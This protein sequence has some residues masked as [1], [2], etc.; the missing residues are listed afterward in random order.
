MATRFSTWWPAKVM[1]ETLRS[2]RCAIY[3]RKSTEEGLDQDFNS[4]QA[5]R[6]AGEA[7]IRSQRQ[8]GWVA[9]PETYDDG[10]YT[11]ANLERPA[12]QRL[13]HEMGE[14]K[15]DCVIVYK[16]D[17]LSRSLLDFAR[18]M[19]VFEQQG[20]SFVSVTQE[21]N[22]T[23]S[24]GRLTL[25]ILLSF[26]QFERE[27][28]GERTRDKLGA[29]R[30]KGKWIGGIPILGYD[31]ASAGGRLVVNAAEAEQVR[32]IFAIAASAEN[33]EKA[34]QE[35]ARRGIETK[36]WTS[37]TGRHHA[38][39]AI[40]KSTLRA[41]LGNVLYIGSIRHK[42]TVY[43]GE[44]TG[45]VDPAIWEQVNRQLEARGRFQTGKK[46]RR[47]Q[48]V[49]NGCVYCDQCG[50]AMVVQATTR[51]GRRYQYF[52]CPRGKSGE[53]GQAPVAIG[54][55]ETAVIRQVCGGESTANPTR[56]RQRLQRVAYHSG[57]RRVRVEM[58]DGNRWEF[59][60]EVADRPGVRTTGSEATGRVPRVSRM[61]ALAIKLEGLMADGDLQNQTEVAR[62]GKVSRARLSQILGLRNLA[63]AIQEKLLWLPKIVRGADPITENRLR[64][65]ALI[66]DWEEQ[67][68]QFAG[69]M[70]GLNVGTNS[71]TSE[72]SACFREAT[73]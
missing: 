35:I 20:V 16:V 14:R 23:S 64:R 36:C 62:I 24:L 70:G 27:I 18:L 33:L 5:Q 56:I 30:R 42:G 68:R 50:S 59:L 29:A 41:L 6:E 66:V 72:N 45:I 11:G 46:H 63:T 47:R 22:T 71:R 12:L 57:T 40:S 67:E 26:A 2:L 55:L 43:P 7:Y 44:Q 28:I 21:F 31:V 9:L 52:G 53:C 17:R 38:G 1:A 58:R 3:T 25:N 54:D 4:L 19:S 49:L 61:L 13:L 60:L 8:L 39:K 65:I 32:E 69:L 37:R 48:A 34:Q 10:G 15:V 73:E 51:H